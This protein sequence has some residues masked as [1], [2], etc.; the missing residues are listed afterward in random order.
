MEFNYLVVLG[1]IVTAIITSLFSPTVVYFFKIRHKAKIDAFN[2]AVRA[3]ARYYA[4][5]LD[6]EFQENKPTC[7]GKSQNVRISSNTS[8]LLAKARSLVKTNFSA[9]AFEEYDEAARTYVSIET[10]P[11]EE[12]EKQQDKAL[13][14]L[15]KEINKDIILQIIRILVI[16]TCIIF[17]FLLGYS[18][19]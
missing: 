3:L 4:E 13:D 1:A 19:G 6:L 10:V 11:N 5:A 14:I 16:I 12:F 2:L 17:V 9:K 7:K 8:G 15:A 18:F